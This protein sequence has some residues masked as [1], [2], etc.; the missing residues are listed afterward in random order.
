MFIVIF[1]V[2]PKAER[3]DDYLDLAKQ[4]KPKPCLS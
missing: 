1:E 4:L 3:W 2:Q